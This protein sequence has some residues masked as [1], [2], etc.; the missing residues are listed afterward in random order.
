MDVKKALSATAFDMEA[1]YAEL[2]KRGLAVGETIH[3]IEL[4]GSVYFLL[5]SAIVCLFTMTFYRSASALQIS[6]KA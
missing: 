5:P 2:R 1:A 4:C 3:L 6:K